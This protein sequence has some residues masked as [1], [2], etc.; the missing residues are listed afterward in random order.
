M[1]AN[2]NNNG[3]ET[4]GL[5]KLARDGSNRQLWFALVQD[6][7]AA[8]PIPNTQAFITAWKWVPQQPNEPDPA[9][10]FTNLPE[11]TLAAQKRYHEHAKAFSVIRRS[12]D[13][14]LIQKT[15]SV[16][17]PGGGTGVPRNVPLLLR[18]LQGLWNNGSTHHRDRLRTDYSTG[19]SS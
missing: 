9:L 2:S 16:P 11:N 19:P 6:L 13:P 3:A 5:P 10:A 8:L 1:S 15:L 12:M 4:R 14:Q 17:W 7:V 18:Y